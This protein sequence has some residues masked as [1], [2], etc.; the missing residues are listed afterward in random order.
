[1]DCDVGKY[2]NQEGKFGGKLFCSDLLSI[3]LTDTQMDLAELH[4]FRLV[5]FKHKEFFSLLFV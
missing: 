1:M 5:Y 2:C 4:S 3:L